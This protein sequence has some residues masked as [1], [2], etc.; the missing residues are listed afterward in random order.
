MSWI[1]SAVLWMTFTYDLKIDLIM[2][3]PPFVRFIFLLTSFVVQLFEFSPTNHFGQ[4]VLENGGVTR[5]VDV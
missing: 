1:C 5:E 2:F 3:E 4:G